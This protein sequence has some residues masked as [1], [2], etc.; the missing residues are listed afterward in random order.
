MMLSVKL[1]LPAVFTMFLPLT[2]VSKKKLVAHR[3]RIESNFHQIDNEFATW[4]ATIL[5]L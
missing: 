1:L 3:V 4:Q 2:E 5:L